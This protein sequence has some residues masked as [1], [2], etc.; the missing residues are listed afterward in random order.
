MSAGAHAQTAPQAPGAV[1]DTG[2][3]FAFNRICYTQVP[4]IER[5]GSMAAQ[6]AWKPLDGDDL[7]QFRTERPDEAVFGWDARLG[8]RIFRIGLTQGPASGVLAE[9]FPDFVDGIATSCTMVLDG[10]DPAD[11]IYAQTLALAGKEPVSANVPKD[12]VLTT[13][14]AGGNDDLKV[15]LVLQTN[16]QNT[17]NLLNVVVLT[18]AQ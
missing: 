15:F 9:M 6:M 18:Q 8:E 13:T 4:V 17:G 3:V 7:D 12:G 5:I 11:E 14:W 16:A 1:A 2:S 10:Q